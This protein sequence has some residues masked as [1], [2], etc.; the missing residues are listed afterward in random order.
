MTQRRVRGFAR[1]GFSMGVML[2]AMASA[3]AATAQVDPE[4][5]DTSRNAP[6]DEGERPTF[7]ETW[8]P[9]PDFGK[10]QGDAGD[11]SAGD[12]DHDAVVGSFSL[13][14]LGLADLPVAVGDPIGGASGARTIAQ[15]VVLAPVIGTRYWLGA[16]AGVEVGFGFSYRSG[17]ISFAGGE[18]DGAELAGYAG[19][20]GIPIAA[21]WGRHYTFVVVPYGA[22]GITSSTDS[23]G[24][25]QSGDDVFGD[26]SVLE[27]GVKAGVE[28]QLG[29][30]GLPGL[31][32]QL[33][34][35]LRVRYESK[36]TNVPT[37]DATT[38]MSGDTDLEE[39][40]LVLSS[41]AGSTLGSAI[42]G[43]IAALYYF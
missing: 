34:T 7:A 36:T 23:R 35:G 43:T 42:A 31:A 14:L 17:T 6:R 25:P 26:A 10:K 27:G 39:T 37:F 3:S 9:P 11:T 2:A 4:L 19:H 21:T 20:L 12:S 24:T 29:A 22:F 8:E 15:D 28:L 13:G 30:I 5:G 18:A 40:S 33:S 38:M 16:R 1:G 41:T 32:L